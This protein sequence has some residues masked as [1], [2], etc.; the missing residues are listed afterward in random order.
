MKISKE[1]CKTGKRIVR[2]FNDEGSLIKE[3]HSYGMFDIGISISY[4]NGSKTE[5][6]YFVNKKLSN[7]K[8]YEKERINFS[9]MPAP[10]I[11][12]EDISGLISNS[13]EKEKKESI[14]KL[15]CFKPDESAKKS[16]DQFCINLI[17]NEM[18]EI[19]EKV[20]K[21][22]CAFG[23]MDCE[24]SDR[25]IKLLRSCG[26]NKI[27]GKDIESSGEVLGINSII[28]ELPKDLSKRK[29]LYKKINEIITDSGVEANRDDGEEYLYIKFK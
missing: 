16:K 24:E 2:E 8:K 27:F 28:L 5:E 13:A 20:Y 25:I 10:D 11:G 19:T 7:R 9:D 1:E 17:K 22:K 3:S 18:I 26:I 29:R 12:L 14:S 6:L 15:K 23:E 21:C 4:E